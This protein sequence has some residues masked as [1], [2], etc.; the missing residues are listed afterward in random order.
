[1]HRIKYRYIADMGTVSPQSIKKTVLKDYDAC[2]LGISLGNQKS[3]L[4]KF[5][6]T[7]KWISAHFNRCALVVGDSIYK[8]TLQIQQNLSIKD[9]ISL[10]LTNG[11]NFIAE[12]ESIVARYRDRCDFDWICMSDVEEN[13]N[14]DIY[15][16]IYKKIYY[17][18]AFFRSQ[19]NLSSENYLCGLPNSQKLLSAPLLQKNIDIC[20]NYFLEES[21]IFTCLCESNWN[22]LV[23]PGTIKPLQI[24]SKGEIDGVPKPMLKLIQI[25]LNLQKSTPYFIRTVQEDNSMQLD[26]AYGF[27]VLQNFKQDEWASL[28]NYTKRKSIQAGDVLL[29]PVN[30]NRSLIILIKG[31]VEILTGDLEKGNVKPIAKCGAIS[32][33]GERSFLGEPPTSKI[34]AALTDCEILILTNQS[35]EKMKR[36]VPKLGLKLLS[37]LAKVLAIRINYQGSS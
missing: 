26:P 35:Y 33:L 30:T 36:Q 37:E 7:I 22:V 17:K 12:H 28:L 24:L 8:Y 6:G 10:A 21:A 3:E 15:H 5:Q 32:F 27:S 20:A 19:I 23:Y 14:F 1:M 11:Q 25:R 29:S 9:A 13:I 34:V 2:M 16:K 4:D 31:N 18:D